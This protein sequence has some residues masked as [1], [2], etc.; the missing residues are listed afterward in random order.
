MKTLRFYVAG[1]LSNAGRVRQVLDAIRE[2]GHTITYDWTVGADANGKFCDPP[3][4][5]PEISSAEIAGVKSADTVVIVQPGGFGA[6]T[7]FGAA[8]ASGKDV[9]VVGTR[10]EMRAGAAYDCIFNWHPLVARFETVENM[11]HHLDEVTGQFQR[12]RR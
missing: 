7:E 9:W 6:H 2:R 10:E 5:W 11:L 4:R 3:E 1:R 12:S 8:L